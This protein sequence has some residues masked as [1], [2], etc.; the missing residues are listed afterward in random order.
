VN[1]AL[2]GAIA[3]GDA[4]VQ[5]VFL[6]RVGADWLPVVLLSRAI[7]LP[8]L[9]ALYARLARDRSPRAVLAVLAVLAAG[10]SACAWWLMGIGSAGAIAAYAMHEIAAG[11]LT[12]H[13]GVYLLAGLGGEAALR[14]VGLVYAGARFGAAAGGAAIVWV[15][16]AAG[17][18]SGMFVVCGAL[19]ALAVL[20]AGSRVVG[21]RRSLPPP[22]APSPASLRRR[23]TLARSPLLVAIVASTITM[24]G[25]RFLLRYQQQAVLDG[26]EEA[27]LARLL[28]GYVV[29]ANL[30]TALLSAVLMGRVLP[31]IGLP[32]ANTAYAVAVAGAQIALLVIPGVPAALFARFADGELKHGLK[33]PVSSLFYEAFPPA[34]R[35]GARAVVLGAASPAAQA[36]GALLL[37]AVVAGAS[38]LAAGAIGLGFC[39][40][41][42]VA[43]VAQNRRWRDSLAAN[44]GTEG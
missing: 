6:A 44:R 32:G 19:L 27:S 31:R 34:A 21:P 30:F 35:A 42:A 24:V 14:G 28:G 16:T 40:V 25:V 36:A 1:A 38:L 33:T 15:A 9:A 18:Q 10:S 2:G 39:A 3:A 26:I 7:G 20:S 8:I 43:T 11:L 22:S 17:A 12:V 4:T 29:A 13:W 37:A 5:S 23:W 41:F